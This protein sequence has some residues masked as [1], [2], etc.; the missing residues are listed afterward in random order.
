MTINL[1]RE[2]CWS[3]SSTSQSS[4]TSKRGIVTIGLAARIKK[5][6]GRGVTACG[7]LD[8]DNKKPQASA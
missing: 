2:R 7:C 6:T 1:W 8:L 5:A 3:R 4:W